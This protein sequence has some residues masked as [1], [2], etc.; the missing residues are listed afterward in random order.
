[1]VFSIFFSSFSFSWLNFAVTFDAREK[2]PITAVMDVRI[3]LD[4]AKSFIET[5]KPLI[6]VPSP[7][8]EAAASV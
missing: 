1:M 7:N 2:A 6:A 5:N 3:G 8:V 4:N